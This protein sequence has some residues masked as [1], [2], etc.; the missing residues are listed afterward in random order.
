MMKIGFIGGGIMGLPMA[1]NLTK[2]GF[3]VVLYNRTYSKIEPFKNDIKVTRDLIEA[4][5]DKDVIFTIVGYPF[6][7]KDLYETI[8]PKCKKGAILVD[9][10]TSSPKLA[11]NLYKAA[12]P[13]GLS[14]LDAP[15]TGGD[16]GAIEAS[17]S[18]MVGGDLSSYEKVLPLFQS[19]GKTITYMG[20]AGSGQMMKL[21]NQITI[22]SNII[23]IAE[24]LAFAKDHD[25]DL[26]KVLSVINGGSAS[27]WQA[28]NNGVKMVKKDYK[29]GFYIKH[30]IKDLRLALDEMKTTLPNLVHAEMLYTKLNKMDLGTQAI[31]EAYLNQI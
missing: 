24:S 7:V 22:A 13:F 1:K 10:T 27:S 12:L 19:M 20:E 21:A 14:I 29:P 16:K 31:I 11:K 15:V 17:L 4:I 6:E 8:L 3:D 5:L 26:N 23:G 9:M 28:L 18:I 25:L 30:F 2:S